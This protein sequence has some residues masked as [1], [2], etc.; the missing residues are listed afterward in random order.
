MLT[1]ISTDSTVPVTTSLPNNLI[2]AVAR[3]M[4]GTK[5]GFWTDT[6]FLKKELIALNDTLHSV[7][8]IGKAEKLPDV[9][10]MKW[11]RKWTELEKILD[12]IIEA[13]AELESAIEIS[14]IGNLTDATSVWQ[15][16]QNEDNALGEILNEI[17]AMV[18]EMSPKAKTKLNFWA[19]KLETELLF[20]YNCAQSLRLKLS[21]LKK[22]SG[23]KVDQFHVFSQRDDPS[24]DDDG[25]SAAQPPK[26]G[27][28]EPNHD[29]GSPP[30]YLP[31]WMQERW[32][33]L[34]VAWSCTRGAPSSSY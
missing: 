33:G 11:N 26:R 23:E 4:T 29:H 12:Q 16:F 31:Q 34:T 14:Q 19:K 9:S 20:I 2:A 21:F 18:C 30:P 32:T 28:E 6:D 3:T 5:I 15:K 1:K 10:E 8:K 24:L 17:R 13:V 27:K 25:N 22:H 7:R